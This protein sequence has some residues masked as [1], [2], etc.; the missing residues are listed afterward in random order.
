MGKKKTV[1]DLGGAAEM[2]VA[3]TSTE[4]QEQA[5][6]PAEEPNE[7]ARSEQIVSAPLSL[8]ERVRRLEDVIATLQ[9]T[10]AKAPETPHI[11][12]AAV[13]AAPPPAPVKEPAPLPPPVRH[14]LLP[15]PQ[16]WLVFEI[17]AELRA[18]VRM[19]F[20]RGYRMTWRTRVL[21]PLLI[22]II[23][24][25]RMWI[26]NLPIIGWLLDLVLYPIL[27]YVL[28]KVLG[29]EAARYRAASPSA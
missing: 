16:T 17:I 3:D 20:D 12:S 2:L 21:V 6:A 22:V 7:Q 10:P 26:G 14:P 27:L 19:F 18:I 25:S 1:V 5:A 4:Q 13:F 8:E 24:L 11:N 15:G 28:F 23:V 9:I 29:R